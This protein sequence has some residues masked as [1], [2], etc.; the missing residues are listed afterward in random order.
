MHGLL[1]GPLPDAGGERCDRISM[2]D[3]QK[4]WFPAKRYGWGWGPPVTWQGW[5]VLIGYVA[6]VAL[7]S[8]GFPPGIFPLLYPIGIVLATCV[9][10]AICFRKGEPPAWRWGDRGSK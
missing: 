1:V 7:I 5:V 2:D 9:L 6:A 8:V 10:L 4:Y 3:R